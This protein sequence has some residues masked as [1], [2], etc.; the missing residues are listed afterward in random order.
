MD[1]EAV[2]TKA[3]EI[4]SVQE[5]AQFL[6][7]ACGDD[8]QLRSAVEHLLRLHAGSRQF[9]ERPATAGREAELLESVRSQP[10]QKRALEE[11]SLEFLEPAEHPGSLGRLQQYEVLEVVGRGGMGIVLKAL[12]TKLNRVVAVKVLA[13]DVAPNATT[14]RRF[15]REARAAAAISHDHVVT[16]HAVEVNERPTGNLPYLVME[17][18]DG[19]S[20]Q[21]VI[22]QEGHLELQEVLRIGRQVAAGLAAAHEQGL[23]HRDVKPA[24]ILLQNGV[25]RVQITDFGLARAVDDVGMTKTGEVT[26][27]P[28]YM[29]PEQALGQPADARSDLFSLGSVLYAMCTGRSPFRADTSPAC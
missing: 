19:M 17:F 4:Q 27:T 12:D 16:I 29:S 25:Q 9:L 8:A 20:L 23:I 1:E 5:R 15:L 13:P 11:T 21:E 28:Q 10:D 3:V 14:R 26:G 18:I 7:E 2:F 22:D 6:D 24:N